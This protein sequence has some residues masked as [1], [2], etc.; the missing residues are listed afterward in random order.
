MVL[1]GTGPARRV[2]IGAFATGTITVLTASPVRCWLS[3]PRADQE[4]NA[5]TSMP[6]SARSAQDAQPEE[7]VLGVDTHRDIHVARW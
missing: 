6:Q 3:E 7:V 5:V 4:P 1:A 2:P